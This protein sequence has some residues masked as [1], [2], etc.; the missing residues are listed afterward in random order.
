MHLQFKASIFIWD[1]GDVRLPLTEQP[2]HPSLTSLDNLRGTL[3][4]GMFI[5][6][7]VLRLFDI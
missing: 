3:A 5:A 6:S 7:F 1:L 4:W 2:F